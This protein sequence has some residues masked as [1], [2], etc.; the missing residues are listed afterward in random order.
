MSGDE[1]V[2][3]EFE[4]ENPVCSRNAG[5][6]STLLLFFYDFTIPPDYSI[7]VFN[8]EDDDESEDDLG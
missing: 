6:A 7:A 1:V 8:Y 2:E 3:F 5:I 4:Y